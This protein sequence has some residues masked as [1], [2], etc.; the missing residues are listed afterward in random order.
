MRDD[1]V[2]RY[3]R[4]VMLPE[5]GGLGQAAL[6]VATARVPLREADPAAELVAATY[7]AAGGVGTLVVASASDAQRAELAAHGADTRVI[8]DAPRG[9]GRE[10]VLAARP[11]WWPAAPGDDTALAFWR[12]G[13]AAS[14]WM[15]QTIDR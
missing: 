6:L 2:R 12:G 5:V 9:E 4:H 3:A 1:Q 13:I 10:L 11:A 15:L 7:L 14:Q 8:A